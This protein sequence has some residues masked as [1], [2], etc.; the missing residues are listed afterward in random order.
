MG[1]GD[2]SDALQ[3]QGLNAEL[4]SNYWVFMPFGFLGFGAQF[5][6]NLYPSAGPDSTA[7]LIILPLGFSVAYSTSTDRLFS[8]IFQVGSGPS[9]AF[10]VFEGTDLLFKVVPFINASAGFSINFRKS[11]SLGLKTTYN[12]F[13]EDKGT[14]TTLTP[15]I[16][17]SFRSW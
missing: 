3:K 4:S 10:L 9:F 2:S 14:L 1:I 12:I 13:F 15:S 11:M 17:A 5:S 16:Y 6:L 7:S 8:V